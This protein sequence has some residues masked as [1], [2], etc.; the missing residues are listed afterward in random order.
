MEQIE[1]E[2]APRAT[3]RRTIDEADLRTPEKRRLAEP[4]SRGTTS[5]AILSLLPNGTRDSSHGGLSAFNRELFRA[6]VLN[7]SF[8]L[9][10]S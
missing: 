2:L 9:P 10:R 3:R 1:A 5:S 6:L 4:H 7:S 8:G